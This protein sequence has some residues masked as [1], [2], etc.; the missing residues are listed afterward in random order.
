MSKID[1]KSDAKTSATKK[2]SK[3]KKA[4]KKL[5]VFEKELKAKEKKIDEKIRN[6]RCKGC[7]KNKI[8]V[9][10]EKLIDSVKKEKKDSKKTK[11]KK[12]ELKK[13]KEKKSKKNKTSKSKQP[14]ESGLKDSATQD[15]EPEK[16]KVE[17]DKLELLAV[18]KSVPT[19]MDFNSK[20]AIAY[21][22]KLEGIYEIEQ[23]VKKDKR[24]TI[25]KAATSR[26][27]AIEG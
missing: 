22:R 23:F 12:S 15:A 18:N 26:K 16:Q 21:L 9:P 14:T 20:D 13:S 11:E 3:L 8:K 6:A 19:S 17:T 4:I 24:I 10:K 1:K 25:K 27:R 5:K 7:K 2:L